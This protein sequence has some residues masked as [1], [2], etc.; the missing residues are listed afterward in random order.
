MKRELQL[1]VDKYI[2]SINSDTAAI[3]AGAGLSVASGL[4]NWKE[5]LRDIAIELQLD[6]D[7]EDDLISL[8]QYYENEKGGRGSINSQLIEE[9][10]KDVAINDNHKIIAS[11]PIKTFW[12]TNYDNLIEKSL[13]AEGKSVDRK[14]CV[15]NLASNKPRRDAVVYK[16]HGDISLPHEAV[17]TKD[18]YD[19]YNEKRQLYTTSLQGDLISK[20]FLFIGFSFEDPNLDYI[21]SRIKILLGSNRREHYCFFR[22]VQLSDFDGNSNE[23]NY[24]KIKQEL[25]IKDLRRFGIQSLLVDEYSE[26]TDVLNLIQ[27]RIKRQNIFISGAAHDYGELGKERTEKILYNLSS[28]LSENNYKIISGFG[29][30][31]G[32]SV[33]NG[34][35][36]FVYESQKKHL[37]DYLISRPFPQNITDPTERKQLW[38]SYREDMISESGIAIFILGNKIVDGQIIPS[39]GLNEEFNIAISQGVKVIPIGLSGFVSKELWEEVLKDTRKYYPDNPELI[40]SI[41][42][43]GNDSLS[44]SEIINH[45]IKSINLL[46]KQV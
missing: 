17:L 36:S 41:T 24:A 7:K 16:M 15:E 40:E 10:T 29:L 1:F 32:S 6:I 18:D 3:F 34:V 43:L 22:K 13:E 44:D 30:G 21:L 11:L 42:A 27:T 19:C 9:F 33:I 25:R 14:I 20:T 31:V 2:K 5:L 45:I 23:F 38:K 26:I 4:V 46:Q 8:A 28:K 39:D 35:L 37:D 12:T